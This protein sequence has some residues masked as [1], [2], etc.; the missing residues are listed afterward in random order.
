MQR[1]RWQRHADG[2]LEKHPLTDE[3]RRLPVQLVLLAMGYAHPKHV[4][5]VDALGLAIDKR[6]NVVASSDNYL[7]SVPAV[8]SCGDMRRAAPWCPY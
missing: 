6:G 1:L 3:I 4:G 2:H 7:T 5:L 8:F